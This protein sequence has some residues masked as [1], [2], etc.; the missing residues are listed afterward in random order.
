MPANDPGNQPI[1][2]DTIVTPHIDV[3]PAHTDVAPAH[4]DSTTFGVHIDAIITPHADAIV[5][6]HSDT[7]PIHADFN[8]NPPHNDT[9]NP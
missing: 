4:A 7:A 9:A 3:A 6:P 2:T 1:H 5:T 8:V